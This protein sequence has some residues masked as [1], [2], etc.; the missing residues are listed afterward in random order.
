M[1]GVAPEHI[2]FIVLDL[3]AAMSDFAALGHQWAPISTPTATLRLADA[4]REATV[5]RYV[6]SSGPLPRVKLIEEVP[7]T[8][9]VRQTG[10]GV[11]HLTY[12]VDDI[13]AA[14]APLIA[15]GACIDADGLDAAGELRYRYLK[16]PSGPRV[17][18][19]LTAKRPEFERWADGA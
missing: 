9:W 11:H 10:G 14:S 5:V 18:F 12:W 19:G 8:Y 2:A 4:R 3:D 1:T 6:T 15:Q 13:E 17:E 7:G 16:L